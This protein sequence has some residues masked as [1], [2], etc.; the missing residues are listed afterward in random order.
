MGLAFYPRAPLGDL[1]APLLRLVGGDAGPHYPDA[2]ACF[3]RALSILDPILDLALGLPWIVGL[4][5]ALPGLLA[6]GDRAAAARPA[7]RMFLPAAVLAA[8]PGAAAGAAVAVLMDRIGAMFPGRLGVL[9][10]LAVTGAGLALA[11][12]LAY[13]VP[14]VVLGRKGPVGALSRSF[15]IAARF[16]RLTVVTLLLE[17][18]ATGFFRRE[19]RVVELAF[20]ALNPES[21]FL[22]LGLGVIVL[23]WV[24]VVRAALLGRVYLHAWGAE[25]P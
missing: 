4:L 3:P 13:A 16:P 24:E 5:A 11:G 17:L 21:V 25:V 2:Y 10:G 15:G 19:P 23:A 7:A 20:D 1:L 14:A 6:G 9:L 8:L 22:S 12:A 18:V